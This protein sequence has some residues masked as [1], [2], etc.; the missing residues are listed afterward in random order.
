[1]SHFLFSSPGQ[2]LTDPRLIHQDAT[3]IHLPFMMPAPAPDDLLPPD[4]LGDPSCPASTPLRLPQSAPVRITVGNRRRSAQSA[5]VLHR[6]LLWESRWTVRDEF[7]VAHPVTTT[8]GYDDMEVDPPLGADILCNE[9]DTLDD[10]IR[11]ILGALVNQTDKWELFCDCFSMCLSALYILYMPSLPA[12]EE[13]LKHSP[14]KSISKL[15]APSDT[16]LFPTLQPTG[17]VSHTEECKALAALNFSARFVS[18]LSMAFN[19]GL[20]SDPGRLLE[21]VVAP[22]IQ[23]CGVSLE[24]FL[25]LGDVVPG[26]AERFD[27]IWRS[28]GWFAKRWGMGG[29]F[30]GL[31]ISHCD[32]KN[33]TDE[34][35]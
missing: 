17:N 16:G 7:G 24:V 35:E 18:D 31:S 27:S 28:M 25:R 21:T 19:K 22:A 12:I 26:A 30:S 33:V 34:S 32:D 15:L 11:T 1:M 13:Q 3:A 23:T 4:V 6:A 5:V 10:D 2:H 29:E 8:P 14:S 20:E 9:Q